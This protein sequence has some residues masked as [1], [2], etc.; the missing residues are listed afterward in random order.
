MPRQ[1]HFL[2]T[3]G[4][5][6]TPAR[7]GIRK[8]GGAEIPSDVELHLLEVEALCKARMDGDRLKH[9]H[10]CVVAQE[11]HELMIEQR[12]RQQ[13]S[14]TRV[15]ASKDSMDPVELGP[16]PFLSVCLHVPAEV[17]ELDEPTVLQALLPVDATTTLC[18]V[19]SLIPAVDFN[20]PQLVTSGFTNSIEFMHCLNFEDLLDAF[21]LPSHF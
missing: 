5:V 9:L 15:L 18:A 7:A 1:F 3:N 6:R 13:R 17:E 10:S 2:Q 14:D 19:N 20:Q 8:K 12:Q 16:D 11:Q 4:H 21:P